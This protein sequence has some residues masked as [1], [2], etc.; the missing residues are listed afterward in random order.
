MKKCKSCECCKQVYRQWGFGYYGDKRFYCSACKEMTEPENGCER[1]KRRIKEVELSAERFD[2][3]EAD[4]VCMY[5]LLI[6]QGWI[7]NEQ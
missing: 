2:E 7:A 3:V 6:E 4:L 1:W 5:K